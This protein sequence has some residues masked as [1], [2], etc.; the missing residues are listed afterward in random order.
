MFELKEYICKIA[1]IDEV[2]AKMEYEVS[3]HPKDNRW[4]V[5]R[6]EAKKFFKDGKR[7]CYIG[8]LGGVVICE[9][10][11]A[12]S[13][14]AAQNSEGLIDDHTAYLFAFRTNKEYRGKG[15]FSKL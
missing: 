5:W 7:I 8:I 12:L 3:I 15:Y 10:T 13:K 4:K 14:N 6:D 2:I 9:A 1:N 11:A